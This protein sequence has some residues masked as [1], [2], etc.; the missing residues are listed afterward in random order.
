MKG[1]HCGLCL[2]KRACSLW[3]DRG[4]V[5][6]TGEGRDQE[7]RQRRGQTRWALNAKLRAVGATEILF[8][9][10]QGSG[11]SFHLRKTTVVTGRRQIKGAQMSRKQWHSA[12]LCP[13]IRLPTPTLP[14][15]A[16]LGTPIPAKHPDQC[17]L[18]CQLSHQDLRAHLW[19]EAKLE[20]RGQRG[21]LGSGWGR[22]RS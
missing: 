8:L 20:V 5:L 7:D 10:Y 19:P 3:L 4:P 15:P 1:G 9:C 17:G 2:G 13:S 11:T 6:G 21:I 14:F 12:G 18:R 16:D 22:G